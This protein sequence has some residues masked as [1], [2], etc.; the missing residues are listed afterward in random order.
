MNIYV[1]DEKY[2]LETKNKEKIL[3]NIRGNLNDEIIN[4]I[5]LDEVEVSLDYFIEN[6]INLKKIDKMNFVTKKN[7]ILIKETLI[8]AKKY[9]INLENALIQTA[10]L[11][12][13]YMVYKGAGKLEKCLN[14]LEWYTEV[15][16]SIYN[17]IDKDEITKKGEDLL[18]KLNIANTTAM[19]ALQKEDYQYFSDIIEVKVVEVLEKIDAFNDMI[20]NNEL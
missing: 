14:G 8:L 7:K 9:L 20:L 3:K 16:N 6:D 18:N 4:K 2:D 10:K 15:T 12:E 11:Y 17:L 13:N 1:D 19:L 5:Y